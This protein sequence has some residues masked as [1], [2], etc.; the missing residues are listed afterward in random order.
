MV[1]RVKVILRAGDASIETSALLN[2]GFE[3]DAPDIAVPTE[4]AKRL[5]LWPPEESAIA[6]IDTGGG[7]VSL[8]YY[9]SAAEL[10]LVLGDRE[11]KRVI[12][13]VLV[14]PH[15]HEVLISDYLASLL[16]IVLLDFKKGFWRLSDDPADKVRTS[17]EPR[18]W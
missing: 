11:G 15:I 18:E 10:E 13:N 5:R 4:L 16:G 17:Y 3:T 14:S 6:L 2:S 12:V 9:E 8:P 1:G 7:E